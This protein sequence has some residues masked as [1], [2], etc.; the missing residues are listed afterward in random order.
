MTCLSQELPFFVSQ[1]SSSARFADD[2]LRRM[3]A[4][5]VSKRTTAGAILAVF[6][7]RPNKALAFDQI[8]NSLPDMEKQN[9][10]TLGDVRDAKR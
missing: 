6:W 8:E 3:T 2:R 9:V 1:G 7:Y 4:G 10:K 5:N